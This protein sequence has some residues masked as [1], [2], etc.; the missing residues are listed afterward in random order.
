MFAHCEVTNK[1]S[2]F[3]QVLIR[4]ELSYAIPV[5]IKCNP[6]VVYFLVEHGQQY[7]IVR[8]EQLVDPASFEQGAENL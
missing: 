2:K 1:Q 8:R 3:I 4:F 7:V 6:T 5:M